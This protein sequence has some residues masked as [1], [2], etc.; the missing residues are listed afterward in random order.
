MVTVKIKGL[1]LCKSFNCSTVE[2]WVM[3]KEAGRDKKIENQV[4]T[5]FLLYSFLLFLGGKKE[6]QQNS[7]QKSIVMNL[8]WISL[9]KILCYIF[10]FVLNKVFVAATK[11]KTKRNKT[12]FIL[13][14]H[15][16]S[17]LNSCKKNTTSFK[18]LLYVRLDAVN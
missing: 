5:S 16:Y 13:H 7:H 8:I 2:I 4:A 11:L 3:G 18:L 12:D 6:V 10:L 1:F 15:D 14:S 17:P 9:L